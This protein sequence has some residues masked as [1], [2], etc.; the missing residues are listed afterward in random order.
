MMRSAWIVGVGLVCLASVFGCG[1]ATDEGTVATPPPASIVAAAKQAS[2]GNGVVQASAVLPAEQG[3]PIV[4]LHTTL[5]N[6]YVQLHERQ[7]PRTVA[8][9]LDYARV[10][11]Y[12]GTLFHQIESGF[13]ALGGAYDRNLK[14]K[15]IRYPVIN[16]AMNGMKNVRG[17]LAMVRESSDPNSAAS[18]FY[19]NLADNPKLDHLGSAPEQ[20]GYCVFGRVIDGLD[21]LDKLS[22][23]KTSQVDGFA[24]MPT[25]RVVLN[26]VRLVPGSIGK[27]A[28]NENVQNTSFYA[29]YGR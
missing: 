12:D 26:S 28:A 9:F 5:G 21:V 27:Q 4:V 18:M 23:A 2:T 1:K 14:A 24:N 8:N 13:V 7:A 15:P 6:L 10:G 11:H 17:T 16:E 29:G 25:D 20:Y 3:D 19:I 22:A